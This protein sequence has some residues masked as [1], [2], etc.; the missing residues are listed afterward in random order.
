M[1]IEDGLRLARRAF[2]ADEPII[3]AIEQLRAAFDLGRA[4]I[5]HD[6]RGRATASVIR[7]PARAISTK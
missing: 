1:N 3:C 4:G 6:G 2:W 7:F 5:L